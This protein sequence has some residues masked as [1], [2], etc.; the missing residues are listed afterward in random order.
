MRP[1]NG[2]PTGRVS[3][4]LLAAGE[5]RRMGERNKLLLPVEGRPL[6]R[7]SLEVLCAAQLKEIVVVLGH[8][9]EA[10]HEALADL[11]A[12]FIVNRAYREGQMSSVHRGMQ[13][14]DLDCEGIMVCLSDQPRLTA[15]DVDALID[16]FRSRASGAILVPLHRGRRGNPIVLDA[17][18]RQSILDGKRNLGCKRL[19]ERNP[20]LVTTLEVD[21]DHYSSDIDT[22]AD[23]AALQAGGGPPFSTVEQTRVDH[24][25]RD[26]GR[27]E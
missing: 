24:G 21:N 19:I 18:H 12:S 5:S 1:E 4:L 16:A 20:E 22:P 7:R 6:V 17:A 9:C 3:A 23:Y 14:L 2:K 15:G 25:Q 27:P 8:E 10:V 13:A 11:P 26:T